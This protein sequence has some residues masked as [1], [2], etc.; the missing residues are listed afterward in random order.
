MV[1]IRLKCGMW[2]Y[3]PGQLLGRGGCGQVFAG[4]GEEHGPVAVKRLGS[5]AERLPREMV[6]AADLVDKNLTCVMPVLDAGLDDTSGRYFIVMPRAERSLQDDLNGGK[7]WTDVE[8]AET[9]LQ[10]ADGLQEVWDTVD[11]IHRDMKPGNVLR[12][13]ERW[14]ITDLS[15]SRFID[16]TTSEHTL[17]NWL[18]SQ[19]AAPE[20]WNTE[21]TTRATDI[22]ALG[23]IGYALLTGLPPF[24]G[25]ERTDFKD[26]HL[27]EP[28]PKLCGHEPG[29]ALLLNWM[30]RKDPTGR[31]GVDRVKVALA[32]VVAGE[33]AGRRG[34]DALARVGAIEAVR[35]SQQEADRERQKRTDEDRAKLAAGG[36]RTLGKIFETLLNEIREVPDV[37]GLGDA[38]VKLGTA[39]LVVGYLRN[40][41]VLPL[42]SFP[43]SGWDV[44]VCAR[45]TVAQQAP[46]YVW[47]ASLW[48]S[49]LPDDDGYRWREVSYRST[50]WVM[51]WAIEDPKDALVALD[52]C[53]A[54]DAAMATSAQTAYS[55]AYGPW[56]IDDEDAGAF[57]E[58]WQ[59]L[60]AQAYEG[61]LRHPEHFPLKP[62]DLSAD[63]AGPPP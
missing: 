4:D 53:G 6:I 50:P 33:T 40:A 21:K 46:P 8:A 61:K 52:E 42:G 27:Q 54:A 9:L 26:Q 38:G 16:T 45:I 56:P 17:Q 44:A 39:Q 23:C 57:R 51:T 28:P 24:R 34:G 32:K 29:L 41:E 20:Q 22:Y 62:E 18:S 19:Y 58:R 48:Y 35:V 55:V 14:K 49:R 59:F 10:I 30:L 7:T 5:G 43:K 37:K 15:V 25:P 31:P 60:L 2:S 63:G 11:V 36:C 47:A 1:T 13:G 12:H 3:D